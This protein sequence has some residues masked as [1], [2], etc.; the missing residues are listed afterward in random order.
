M[1]RASRPRDEWRKLVREWESSSET[2][3]DFCDRHDL[4]LS[5]FR[6]WRW[7]LAQDEAGDSAP[8]TRSDSA[9]WVELSSIEL[10]A[11]D[12]SPPVATD[13]TLVL[14]EGI[15]IRVPVG[16][17]APTLERLIRSLGVIEC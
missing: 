14:G 9:P 15:E 7:R 6:W 10:P 5:T 11:A 8:V 16:F 2:A 1:A 4:G 12:G 17:D 3:E 13:L